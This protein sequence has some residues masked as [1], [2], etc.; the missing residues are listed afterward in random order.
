MQ[1]PRPT[2]EILERTRRGEA[3]DPADIAALT[4]AWSVGSASDAQMSAWCAT[5][6]LRGVSA[7]AASSLATVLLGGGDRLE[8]TSLGPTADIRSTGGVGDS[9][10]V[11]AASAT[12]ASLGVII[13]ST[14]NRGISHTGG[15]L[16]ALEA[17]PGMRPELTLEEYVLQARN[18]G[19][20]IAE[21]GDTLVPGE[22][23]L[24]DLRESTATGRGDALVAV[25]AAVRGISGGAGNLIVGIP[26]GSGALVPDSEHATIAGDLVCHIAALWHRSVRVFPD[27]RTEPLAGVSGHALEIA[28]AA[29]VL[30]GEGDRALRDRVVQLADAAAEAAGVAPGAAA[31]ID[32]GRALATAERWVEA[33]GGDPAVL[34]DSAL[35]VQSLLQHHVVAT[36]TG[37]VEAVDAGVVG[38]AT[39]WLGAGRLD[40]DQVIDPAVGVEIAARPG[41]MVHEGD[42]LGIVHASDAWLADRAVDMLADAW[43]IA[44]P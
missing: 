35:L 7:E 24:A 42:V 34:T 1:V 38:L 39:R 33:Q 23:R 41:D 20:V 25:S 31:A 21:A 6:D 14:G 28:A 22:R 36:A 29:A 27:E 15:I 18:F 19:I 13:A 32:D 44:E 4:N 17:I 12:A 5:A 2:L 9:A 26:G 11:F 37:R 40:P 8:L 16:D 30:R 10:L 43:V 3:I